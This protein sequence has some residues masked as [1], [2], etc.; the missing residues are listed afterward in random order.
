MGFDR[1]AEDISSSDRR[2]GG[3]ETTSANFASDEARRCRANASANG[4]AFPFPRKMMTTY[5]LAILS[6]KNPMIRML[7]R[8]TTH[9]IK[10]V[11]APRKWQSSA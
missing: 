11:E 9:H 7:A 10:K 6:S 2:V 4:C 3:E 8:P 5:F 1:I